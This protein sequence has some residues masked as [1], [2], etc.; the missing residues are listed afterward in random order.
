MS[1][2]WTLFGIDKNDFYII[3]G[4]Q[5]EEKIKDIFYDA[6]KYFGTRKGTKLWFANQNQGLGS[7]TPLSLLRDDK[8]IERIRTSINKLR[9][10]MTA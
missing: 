4:H 1:E 10:G 5:E 8:G 3:T 9:Y 7:V 6:L 2:V